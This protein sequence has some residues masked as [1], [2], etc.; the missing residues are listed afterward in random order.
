MGNYEQLKAAV[1]NVIKTNGT[2]A[3]S[4]QV[5]QNTLL[6]MINSLGSNYQFVGIAATNTNPGIPDQNVFYIAGEG[7]Y[8]NFSNISVNMGELAVLKWNGAWSKQTVK[9]GLPPNELNISTLYPANGE[10]GT[11]RYTLAGAIAKVPAEYRVQGVKVAFVN[12]DNDTENWEFKGGRW[13]VSQFSSLGSKTSA[14][15]QSVFGNLFAKEANAPD[16]YLLSLF[17]LDMKYVGNSLD[18]DKGYTIF[19]CRKSDNNLNLQINIKME[20]GSI[21]YYINNFPLSN[22]PTDYTKNYHQVKI[23]DFEFVF[24][25]DYFQDFLYTNGAFPKRKL[26]NSFVFSSNETIFKKI[27]RI[28][29]E[30]KSNNEEIT[31]I[32]NFINDSVYEKSDG[33][34]DDFNIFKKENLKTGY[35][36]NSD[37]PD[38]YQETANIFYVVCDYMPIDSIRTWVYEGLTAGNYTDKTA[39]ALFSDKNEESFIKSISLKKLPNNIHSIVNQYPNARFIRFSLRTL[40]S[41]SGVDLDTFKYFR[42]SQDITNIILERQESQYNGCNSINV[43]GDSYSG[44]GCDENR[45]FIWFAL[46]DMNML[47]ALNKW[48]IGGTRL[49]WSSMDGTDVKDKLSMVNRIDEMPDS[50]VMTIMAGFNDNI[51]PYENIEEKIGDIN[52]DA[53]KTTIIGAYKYII[54]RHKERFPYSNCK[55]VLMTYPYSNNSYHPKL[56]DAIRTIADYYKLPLIDFDKNCGFKNGLN[57]MLNRPNLA[58]SVTWSA[59]NTRINISDGFSIWENNTNSNG[60][61]YTEDYIPV[62]SELYSLLDQHGRQNS[63]VLCYKDSDGIKEFLGYKSGR[64]IQMFKGTTH[65]RINCNTGYTDTYKIYPQDGE[66]VSDGTHPNL[67]GFKTMYP[68]FRQEIK[69]VLS[70]F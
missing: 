8:T 13:I 58:E 35:Y 37:Y 17:I 27:E 64:E 4:G 19:E 67:L 68:I 9:V 26:N 36:I 22:I 46:R 31:E 25:W 24:N 69:K 61:Q 3:I 66:F 54:E 7:T 30:S 70:T 63:N 14:S 48:A 20:D 57:C 44:L 18:K 49:A 56:N 50:N 52:S 59:E 15:M 47:G 41:G 55:I 32:K 21:A 42:S 1:S 51:S 43:L 53:D 2:Q 12:E 28:S 33:I 40:N 45:G 38:T 34:I 62:D 23:G 60:W 65:I 39:L 6:T 29:E 5:L 16:L 10:G 11:N